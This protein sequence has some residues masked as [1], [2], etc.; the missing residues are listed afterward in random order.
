MAVFQFLKLGGGL[1]NILEGFLLFDARL[2]VIGGRSL[3]KKCQLR[4]I[5]IFE[6]VFQSLGFMHLEGLGR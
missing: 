6:R 5:L 4:K 2:S 3:S 1:Q